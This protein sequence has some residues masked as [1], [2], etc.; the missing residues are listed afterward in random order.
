MPVSLAPN[1]TAAM[2]AASAAMAAA[3]ASSVV[4]VTP[5]SAVAVAIAITLVAIPIR[6]RTVPH[7]QH[8]GASTGAALPAVRSAGVCIL[9]LI[10]F[11][12]FCFS[13]LYF[14]TLP[15][16]P[17]CFFFFC[18]LHTVSLIS[19]FFLLYLL[20]LKVFSFIGR[21]F[22]S[23]ISTYFVFSFVVCISHY[24]ASLCFFDFAPCTNTGETLHFLFFCCYFYSIPFPLPLSFV[25]FEKGSFF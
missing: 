10:C 6:A 14:I 8:C 24:T 12:F 9:Y 1:R 2:A 25:F 17:Y 16:F 13:P 22:V 21:L 3:V 7:R 11:L 15:Y 18:I 20:H 4:V 5:H 19:L 23:L